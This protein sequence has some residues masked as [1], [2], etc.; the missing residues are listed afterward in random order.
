MY[1]IIIN[2]TCF[3]LLLVI[4]LL[5]NVKWHVRLPL[6]LY[7][8]G[9][10]SLKSMKSDKWAES[11]WISPLW[12]TTD[13]GKDSPLAFM[14][15]PDWRIYLQP[16]WAWL[17]LFTALA[18]GLRSPT[19]PRFLGSTAPS[20]SESLACQRAKEPSQYLHPTV[21]RERAGLGNVKLPKKAIFLGARQLTLKIYWC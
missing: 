12:E 10:N 19:H 9:C 14:Q 16:P 20:L 3:F 8:K 15:W 7:W 2:F 13:I 18:F 6:Y 5:E 4:R 17:W 21:T 1:I 11:R